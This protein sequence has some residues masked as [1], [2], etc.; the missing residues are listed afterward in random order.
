[1]IRVKGINMP[2][3]SDHQNATHQ[4][5]VSC[6]IVRRSSS[7]CTRLRGP[8]AKVHN[9]L[10]KTGGLVGNFY[11]LHGKVASSDGVA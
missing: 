11:L 7:S 4:T 8:S 2:K 6:C 10:Y 1:M 9:G 5:W 3:D